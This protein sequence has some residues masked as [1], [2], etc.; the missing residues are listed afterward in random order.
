MNEKRKSVHPLVAIIC[1][2][3]KSGTTVLNEILRRHPRLDSGHE[4]GVLMAST[5]REFK[6]VHRL[7]AF[8]QNSWKLTRE[9]TLHCC[10][11][12]GWGT[13]YQRARD[14]SPVITDKSTLIFDKTPRYM[15]RLSE[16]MEKVPEL[17]CVVNV[18]DPRALMHSWACWSGFKDSPAA[19]LED[20]FESNCERF[21]NYAHGYSAA[22]ASG[23]YRLFLN[24]FEI[25][26]LEPQD[27]MTSIFN[28][29]GYDFSEEY[30][31]FESEHLVYGNTLTRNHLFP[32]REDFSDA[33]CH[34]ILDATADY[35][36]WHFHD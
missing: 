15:M 5:P 10:D 6:H 25:M 26:C 34:R 7:Y 14:A 4:V 36:D 29:L 24:R 33:L 12:D 17:P 22:K 32:Y 20:N 11:T 28:F 2:F 18:R 9:Q 3:E 35:S 21:L 27:T 23:R 8:F 31:F 19:W 13:F 16:V 30:M 1:G